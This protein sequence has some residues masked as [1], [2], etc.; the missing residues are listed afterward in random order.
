LGRRARRRKIEGGEQAREEESVSWGRSNPHGR[1]NGSGV[2]LLTQIDG[3]QSDRQQVACLRKMTTGKLGWASVGLRQGKER[4]VGLEMAQS[5]ERFF[6]SFKSIFY[7][8]FPNK[9]PI[10]IYLKIQT[11][12]KIFNLFMEPLNTSRSSIKFCL[13]TFGNILRAIQNT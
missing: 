3:E 11:S 5:K 10:L 1:V 6:F 4:R 13:Q 8:C 12:F 2:H 7:F 9:T